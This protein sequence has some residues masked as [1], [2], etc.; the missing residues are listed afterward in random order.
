[1]EYCT[2]FEKYS[3][4]RVVKTFFLDCTYKSIYF[5]YYCIFYL[6]IYN[7]TFYFFWV[8][9]CSQ[10]FCLPFDY[11]LRSISMYLRIMLWRKSSIVLN[12]IFYIFQYLT[13]Y[14]SYQYLWVG[15]NLIPVCLPVSKSSSFFK[16]W[17]VIF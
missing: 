10:Q 15:T 17:F 5:M 12:V 7:F 16:Y 4:D 13:G 1:M 3:A 6:C 2:M 8:I 9:V 14:V 11:S